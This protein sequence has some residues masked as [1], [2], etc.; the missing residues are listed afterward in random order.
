[1]KLKSQEMLNEYKN[2]VFG[3]RFFFSHKNI[4]LVTIKTRIASDRFRNFTRLWFC[5]SGIYERFIL[6]VNEYA[7]VFHN[8]ECGKVCSNLRCIKLKFNVGCQRMTDCMF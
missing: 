4:K 7:D 5:S 6:Y 8:A 3:L 1:M 2:V